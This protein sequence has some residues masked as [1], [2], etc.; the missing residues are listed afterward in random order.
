MVRSRDIRKIIIPLIAG[1]AFAFLF[2][3][4]DIKLFGVIIGGIVLFCMTLYNVN[5][6]IGVAIFTFPFISN[7]EALILLLFIVGVFVINRIFISKT[8]IT[9]SPI[10][11]PVLVFMAI[12]II[13]TLLSSNTMGSIRDLSI[14]LVAISFMFT[15][16]NSINNKQELNI[17]VT[18]F[19]FAGVLV[20][21]YGLYQFQAG[22]QLDKAWVDT[23]N[24][25][26]VVIRVYSVFGNPNI[27]AEYLIMI[28]PF[29][30]ALFWSSKRLIKK[31]I[32]L[33]TTLIL[34]VA[35]VL[36][37]SRGGW[38]GF[39]FGLIVFILLV[40]KRW[41]LGA[42]P[43]GVVSIFIMPA[44]I[45]NR[46]IS[47]ANLNDSSIVTRLKI[48]SITLDIIKDNWLLGV[49]FGYLPFKNTFTIYI[50]TMNVFHAHNMYLE[51]VAEMGIFGLIALLLLIFVV[52]K[53]AIISI[54]KT[55]GYLS[56]M[57]AGAIAAFASII[58]HGL[59]DSILY[60]PKIIITFWILISFI[61]SMNRL[62]KS[63]QSNTNKNI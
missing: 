57:S 6:G 55:K 12:A 50:R 5:I 51:T 33:C 19:V 46:I 31:I 16:I 11:I 24:N 28:L 53:Y 13:S 3:Y 1:A 56:V 62:S 59:F 41:L 10:D 22:V 54:R 20:S 32:F 40:D 34:I 37:S 29:S 60:I 52:F 17:I 63:E 47:I 14:H 21:L 25:P 44:S 58:C 2:T 23:V 35:L 15:M 42:I 4:L 45:I 36:T 8:R 30:L 61:I 27:L 43:I 18:V 39:A 26:D 38:V 49:G 9:K 48:Y 7:T